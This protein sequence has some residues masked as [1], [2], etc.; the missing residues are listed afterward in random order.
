MAKIHRMFQLLLCFVHG[1][2][3]I[4]LCSITKIPVIWTKYVDSVGKL[5]FN[6]FSMENVNFWLTIELRIN[7]LN[8]CF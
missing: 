3:I 4:C 6:S 7:G 8:F 5:S 2:S 1:V